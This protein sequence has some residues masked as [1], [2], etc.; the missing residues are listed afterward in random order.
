MRLEIVVPIVVLTALAGAEAYVAPPQEDRL[1]A[2][3]R[4]MAMG[5]HSAPLISDGT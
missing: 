1:L 4:G 3:A 2:D 5:R